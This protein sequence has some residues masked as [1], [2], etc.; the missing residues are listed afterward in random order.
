MLFTSSYPP[1]ELFHPSNYNSIRVH[2]LDDAPQASPA[3][4]PCRGIVSHQYHQ[5]HR[6][7]R[8]SCSS[9]NLKYLASKYH[10]IMNFFLLFP[11]PMDVRLIVG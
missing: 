1:D 5:Y 9:Y 3:M 4:Y 10:S 2:P 7:H 8:S 11:D 6:S